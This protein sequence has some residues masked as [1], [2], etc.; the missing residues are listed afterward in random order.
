MNLSGFVDR[1]VVDRTGLAGYF[2]F[3]LRYAPDQAQVPSDDPSLF[4]AL[5]EQ[6][7]VRLQA[8]RGAVSVIAIEMAERP[9]AN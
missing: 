8:S 2:A 7:G 3:D 5:Q 4:A 6:L 1:I 9:A